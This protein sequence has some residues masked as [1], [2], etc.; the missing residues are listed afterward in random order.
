MLEH[1]TYSV[2][3][4]VILTINAHHKEK[5][6]YDYLIRATVLQIF[7]GAL[8]IKLQLLSRINELIFPQSKYLTL[9]TYSTEKVIFLIWSHMPT[10]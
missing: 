4:T 5:N 6:I 8:Q 7:Q 2:F 1:E 3:I 10:N 9:S